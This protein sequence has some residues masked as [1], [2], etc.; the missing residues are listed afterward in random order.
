MRMYQIVACA[1]L[2]VALGAA[3]AGAQ[4]QAQDES[5][6]ERLTIGLKPSAELEEIKEQQAK[7]GRWAWTVL[8]MAVSGY[9]TNIYESPNDEEGSILYGM[10]LRTVGERYFNPRDRLKLSLMGTASPLVDTSKVAEYTQ[11]LSARYTAR[12]SKGLRFSLSGKVEHQNDDEVNAFG[13]SLSQ[14]YEHFA[15]RISPSMR[16]KLAPGHSLRLSFPFKFKD[17][18]ET[19]GEDS[20]DWWEY[21]PSLRYR[22][23]LSDAASLALSYAF[24]IREYDED[25]AALADG[26]ELLTNPE[27]EHYYHKVGLKG[28]W[29]P[30]PMLELSA[31]YKLRVKDDQYKGFESYDEHRF[32]LGFQLSP[33]PELIFHVKASYADR[34]YDRRPG[35]LP[36]EDLEWDQLRT[37]VSAQYRLSKNLALFAQ[38][39]FAD[40]DSNRDL[41]TSYRDY[42][43]HKALMGVS[44]GY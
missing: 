28:R 30:T 23:K 31:A 19:S 13:R 16:F 11:E 29:R 41:G 27:E 40:R 44:V 32:E 6:T 33:T 20:L 3:P 1:G 39:A 8:G 17:Y 15:Y 10:G 14:D 24:S 21:G 35:D 22:L 37:T 25:L 18:E 26:T 34:Q 2:A 43:V 38:Y 9:D 5:T 4:E 42:Q 12:L 7:E 36:T